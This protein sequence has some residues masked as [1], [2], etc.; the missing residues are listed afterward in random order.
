MTDLSLDWS[1]L[2]W[3]VQGGWTPLRACCPQVPHTLV[4]EGSHRDGP[5]ARCPWVKLL[6]PGVSRQSGCADQEF[7]GRGG[8]P[9]FASRVDTSSTIFLKKSQ[10]RCLRK[11]RPCGKSWCGW[12]PLPPRFQC[13]VKIVSA[14][15]FSLSGRFQRTSSHWPLTRRCQ[16]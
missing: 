2:G 9:T 13:W 7:R 3:P 16:H 14:A 11:K 8:F 1:V 4:R 15:V 5:R 12:R 6:A 10:Y